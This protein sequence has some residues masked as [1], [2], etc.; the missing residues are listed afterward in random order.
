MK[1]KP[2]IYNLC[3][4]GFDVDAAP[5]L[6]KM[7]VRESRDIK[8]PLI[9]ILSLCLYLQSS[10]DHGS[11]GEGSG[12]KD[13]SSSSG[14]GRRVGVV[15]AATTGAAT[16][17]QEGG[18]GGGRGR[19]VGLRRDDSGGGSLS[20]NSDGSLTGQGSGDSGDLTAVAARNGSRLRSRSD[21][22]DSSRVGGGDGLAGLAAGHTL[23]AVDSLG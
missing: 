5:F 9:V 8:K 6:Y 18:H 11:D 17:G 19:D 15:A 22:V 21:G 14:H 12:G 7:L 13:T 10:S 1:Y 16:S 20:G 2:F 3:L 4:G 23:L